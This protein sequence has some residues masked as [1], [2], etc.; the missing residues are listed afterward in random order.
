MAA[1]AITSLTLTASVVLVAAAS[2]LASAPFHRGILL[3]GVVVT[4]NDHFRVI[5]QGNV[6]VRGQR[7]IG[8]WSGRRAPRGVRVGRA[9]VVAP[10]GALIFP[11]LINLHDHPSWSVL[12]PWPPPSSDA[13]PAFGRP[14]GREPYANRYQWNG[15]AGFDDSPPEERRLIAAPHDVLTSGL[16]LTAETTKWAELRELLGGVTSEQGAG[17][18]PATDNLLARDVDNVNF[19][20]DR[21]EANTF[22]GPDPAL[23]ARERAGRVDAYI[24]HLAEGVPDQ[25]R[26]PGDTYS[27][28][29]E[30]ASLRADHL[31]NDETVIIHGTALLPADFAAMRAAGSPRANRTGDGLGAKLVWSPLSNLLLYGHT[32]NVYQ[33]LAAGV[34]VSLGTDWSPSGSGN[35]LEELKIADIALHNRSLLGRFR[36]LVP[37]LHSEKALDRELVAMVT[38]NPAVTLRWTRYVGSVAPGKFADLAVITRPPGP[39]R[40]RPGSV[41]RSLIDATDRDVHLTLVGGD[42]LVGD[43]NLMRALKGNDFETIRSARLG[44]VKAIDVTK[45]GVPKGEETF[46]DLQ[47]ILRAA[48]GALG[49]ADGY[50]YLN[51]HVL[52]GALAG[53]SSQQFR[54]D[55]LVPVFGTTANGRLNAESIA[56]SPILPEDDQFR[57]D[58][59]EGR[60]NPSGAIADPKPP[61]GLYP[62]NVNQN[63]P[64]GGNPFANFESRWYD[65]PQK[66]GEGTARTP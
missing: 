1:R 15:A 13:Q 45:P 16:G 20:R 5:R 61:F 63:P 32:T 10:P 7:I 36:R 2:A 8:V 28:R 3:K 26:R 18:D 44:F 9:V 25:D 43:V 23:V 65:R 49:G 21:V 4:M 27:S 12:P 40:R 57:F 35:L 39:P 42:P 59:I 62:S 60:R 24:I 30:F 52:G 22:P 64:G 54:A 33:A 50:A 38:R 6:L 48:L 14:T 37:R 58:E 17:P 51:A 56:L 41:Y 11:G 31:L 29:G 46:A 53:L 47:A 34:T 66:H 55:Y 19:G